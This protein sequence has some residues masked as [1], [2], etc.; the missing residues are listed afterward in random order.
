MP[1]SLERVVV[2]LWTSVG[3]VSCSPWGRV[4]VW[5]SC[6]MYDRSEPSLGEAA[7]EALP[8]AVGLEVGVVKCPL[9]DK[10]ERGG[11]VPVGVSKVS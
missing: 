11:D 8:R 6:I 4:S 9:V 1:C 10:L 7:D 5:I 2:I 3:I